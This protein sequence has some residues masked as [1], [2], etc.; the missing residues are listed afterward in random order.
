M[1]VEYALQCLPSCCHVYCRRQTA[2][3]REAERQAAN[4]FMM[5]LQA[6]NNG[7][8]KTSGHSVAPDPICLNNASLH[9]LQ[10]LQPWADDDDFRHHH[11]DD[12]DIDEASEC[13]DVN[14][15]G[16][17]DFD[18]QQTNY[19]EDDSTSRH[20]RQHSAA[21]SRSASPTDHGVHVSLPGTA[22]IACSA[23]DRR[24]LVLHQPYLTAV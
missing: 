17:S 1:S 2:E 21:S 10:N 6:D 11:D 20:G 12:V 7:S 22:V 15:T 13:G 3:E 14:D 24:T 23:V 5:S 9:A 19:D 16:H 18:E 8:G 4:R